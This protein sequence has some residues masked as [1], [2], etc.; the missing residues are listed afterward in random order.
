MEGFYDAMPMKEYHATDARSAS[1]L[2]VQA[3]STCEL[4]V[5]EKDNQVEKISTSLFE[6][7]GIHTS[8]QAEFEEEID[9]EYAVAPD[10]RKNSTEYKTWLTEVCGNRI[11][12]SQAQMDM[13]IGCREATRK[14]SVATVMIEN[15]KNIN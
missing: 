8:L 15:G 11:P 3:Y 12:V 4:S 10:V 14:H 7:T 1:N 6:G 9:K 5:Y 13:F 2:I